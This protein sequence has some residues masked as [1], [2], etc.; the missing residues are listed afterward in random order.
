MVLVL[1]LV[2]VTDVAV[3]A[4]ILRQRPRWS[5]IHWPRLVAVL[6]VPHLASLVIKYTL[7]LTGQ[8]P[9]ACLRPISPQ[10]Y[11]STANTLKPG[12][13]TRFADGKVV[14]AAVVGAVSVFS[15]T[16]GATA[17][18]AAFSY[19]P[20]FPTGR[21]KQARKRPPTILGKR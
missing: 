14:I 12:S 9:A 13:S 4:G 19:F 20:L 1:V 17:R 5:I 2:L 8:R 10:L 6:H 15:N 21:H 11:P 18:A 3:Y 7:L 16:N